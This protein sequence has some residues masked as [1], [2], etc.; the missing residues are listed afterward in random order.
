MS[1][2][3]WWTSILSCSLGLTA[4]ASTHAA[5]GGLPACGSAITPAVCD[6]SN[7]KTPPK[8]NPCATAYKGVFYANDFSYLNDPCYSGHCFGDCLKLM[9]V[10][11]LEEGVAPQVSRA[12]AYGLER[13]DQVAIYAMTAWVLGEDFPERFTAAGAVLNARD[14]TPEDKTEWLEQWT[15]T[16]LEKLEEGAD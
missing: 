9:P 5:D 3:G 13:D 2:H 4:F 15:Q 12:V 11:E 6:A 1:R 16:L 8:P 14:T 10:A 7:A